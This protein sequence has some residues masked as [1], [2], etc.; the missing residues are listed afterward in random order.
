MHSQSDVPDQ[1]W[2]KVLIVGWMT[3]IA[4]FEIAML[5]VPASKSRIEVGEFP[6]QPAS[7]LPS[8]N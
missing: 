2:M 3:R 7:N 6:T 4:E 8:H 5:D 1:E